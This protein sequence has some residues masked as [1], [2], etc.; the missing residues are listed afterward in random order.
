MPVS[1]EW[2]HLKAKNN[3]LKHQV[4]FEEASSIFDDPLFIT[5]LDNEHSIDEERYISIGLSNKTRVLLVAHTERKDKVR[6][7]SARK[8]TENEEKFYQEAE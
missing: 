8:A 7:I 4:A 2:D 6:I 5:F 1:F 3:L